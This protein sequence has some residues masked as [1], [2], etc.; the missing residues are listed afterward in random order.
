MIAVM[1]EASPREDHKEEYLKTADALLP[2]M[3]EIDGF[4]SLERFESI[5]NRSKYLALAFF[6]DHEALLA[7]KCRGPYSD[8][9]T[10]ARSALY[11]TY[12]LRIAD[13]TLDWG[14]ALQPIEPQP[15][16]VVTEAPDAAEHGHQHAGPGRPGNQE[17][18]Q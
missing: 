3:Q 17:H 6:R 5:N 8:A 2:A 15:M 11:D 16:A 7:W 13:V 14:S 12:R 10:K 4:L 1:F 9:D 18:D